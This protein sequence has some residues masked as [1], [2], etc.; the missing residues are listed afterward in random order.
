MKRNVLPAILLLTA[1]LLFTVPSTFSHVPLTDSRIYYQIVVEYVDGSTQIVDQAP[2]LLPAFSVSPY[3][4]VFNDKTV[5]KLIF[6]LYAVIHS[7]KDVS[8]LTVFGNQ[9]SSLYVSGDAVPYANASAII[10]GL[11]GVIERDCIVE[12]LSTPIYASMLTQAMTVDGVDSWSLKLVANV[13]ANFLFTDNSHAHL[14][15]APTAH[16]TY[17]STQNT[18]SILNEAARM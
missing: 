6:N 11:Q 7:S 16:I 13:T 12:V 4:V 1:I 8:Q 5:Y 14:K 3:T 10:N 9:Q 18:L 15:L 17:S 2:L